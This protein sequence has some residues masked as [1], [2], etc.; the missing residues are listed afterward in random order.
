MGIIMT[1]EAA[2]AQNVSFWRCTGKKDN[3]HLEESVTSEH[4]PRCGKAKP[5]FLKSIAP[6]TSNNKNKILTP[7]KNIKLFIALILLNFISGFTTIYGA[8]Q[9]LP[10]FP[11]I[12]AGGTIQF[13]L[14]FLVY[15]KSTLAD[16]KIL[17]WSIIAILIFLSTYTS[18]FSY[19]HV[20]TKKDTEDKG[21]TRAISSHQRLIANVYTPLKNKIN[22]LNSEIQQT[23]ISIQDEKNGKRSSAKGEGP[24]Y[25]HLVSKKESLNKR[26]IEIKLLLESLEKSFEYDLIGKTS[27]EIFQSDLKALSQVNKNCLTL[28]PNYVCLSDEYLAILDPNHQ[29]HQKFIDS[30]FDKDLRIGLL[31]PILKIRLLED[32]ALGSAFLAL[33]MDGAI[34][35]LGLGVEPKRK[36]RKLSLHLHSSPN[37]FFNEL[38]GLIDE[39]LLIDLDEIDNIKNKEEYNNLLQNL[40]VDTYWVTKRDKYQWQINDSTSM[41][42]LV[43]WLV[44]EREKYK[45][46]DI[47]T[48]SQYNKN[49]K[50]VA[51]LEIFLPR[52]YQ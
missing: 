36:P 3:P 48:E 12:L 23:N 33:M 45:A 26:L 13:L 27:A 10:F 25:K 24:V 37:Q 6:T 19:Y 17:K 47:T 44:D 4:C 1:T 21:Y 16:Q 5:N 2:L 39:N 29:L 9:I 8:I 30:Y 46:N 35:L 50:V 31:A 40:Q 18:F 41:Q 11:A 52:A 7:I 14:F 34:I 51:Q 20:L 43:H 49:A 28:E 22:S 42:A 32:G 15:S 38:L